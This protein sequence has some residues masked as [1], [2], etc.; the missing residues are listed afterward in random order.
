MPLLTTLEKSSSLVFDGTVWGKL[1]SRGLYFRAGVRFRSDVVYEDLFPSFKL[2]AEAK[3]IAFYP[4]VGYFW[5]IREDGSSITQSPMAPHSFK[6]RIEAIQQCYDYACE[7]GLDWRIFRALDLRVIQHDLMV[8]INRLDSVERERAMDYAQQINGLVKKWTLF[9]VLEDCS[10]MC[11]QKY[12]YLRDLDVD[13]LFKVLAWQREYYS[14]VSLYPG[15]KGGYGARLPRDLF[16]KGRKN[17]TIELRRYP[18]ICKLVSID[19]DDAGLVLHGFAYHRR[20]T[21]PQGSQAI[22]VYLVNIESGKAL[23]LEA[24]SERSEYAE[25]AYGEVIEKSTG[26]AYSYDLE[27]AGFRFA[28]PYDKLAG[29]REMKGLNF[30]RVH[31]RNSLEAGHTYTRRMSRDLRKQLKETVFSSPGVSVR[32][33]PGPLDTARV[34]VDYQDCSEG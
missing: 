3:S 8:I 34:L 32:I 5:R 9:D 24:E 14:T 18:P 33:E 28:L 27:G 31:Y 21:I 30:I 2:K 12:K 16:A 22:Q 7:K 23:R 19:C 15:K 13:S 6:C 29:C 10:L 20:T 4:G 17:I 25:E 26:K 11:R 1:I